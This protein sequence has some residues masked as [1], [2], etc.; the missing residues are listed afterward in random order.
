MK[1]LLT[2]ALTV[3]FFSKSEEVAEV[4]LSRGADTGHLYGDG[5]TL[6]HMAVLRDKL[7]ILQAL[8]KHGAD[9]NVKVCL[10]SG[11]E[12]W[13]DRQPDKEPEIELETTLLQ[14]RERESEGGGG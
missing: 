2:A 6:A 13:R 11:V 1:L 14:E 10:L 5:H 8:A 12:W 3:L 4:L 7:V 9:L